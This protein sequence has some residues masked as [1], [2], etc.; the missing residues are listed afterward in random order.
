MFKCYINLYFPVDMG[1]FKDNDINNLSIKLF[2][3][4]DEDDIIKFLTKKLLKNILIF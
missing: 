1:L 2:N 3:D 4:Y